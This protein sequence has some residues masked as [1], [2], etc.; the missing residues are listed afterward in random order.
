MNK[1][2]VIVDIYGAEYWLLN[3]KLHRE[4]G[5]AVKWLPAEV[6]DTEWWIKGV[7][8]TELGHQ[9]LTG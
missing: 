6:L 1:Y 2:K 9:A 3:N 8:V 4:D 7:R 5:P